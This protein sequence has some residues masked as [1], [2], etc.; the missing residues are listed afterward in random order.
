MKKIVVLFGL[1]LLFSCS[2]VFVFTD[3]DSSVDFSRYKSFAYYKPQIDEVDLSDLD[4]RRILRALDTT[5]QAKGLLKSDAPDLLVSFD[6]QAKEK[7]YVN[8]FNTWGWGWGWNPWFWG[9]NYNN[10]S[11]QTEGTLYINLIDAKS[12]QLVWQGKGRGRISEYT[13][14]RDERIAHF[15]NEIVAQYPPEVM[16]N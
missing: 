10:V 2:S 15:V 4:K 7:V 5:L 12:K 14:K 16:A 9:P 3:H 11:R 8:N 13:T 1:S 6:T